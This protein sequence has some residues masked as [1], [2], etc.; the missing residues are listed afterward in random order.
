MGCCSSLN[1]WRK[2]IKNRLE[3]DVL[4]SVVIDKHLQIFLNC[5]GRQFMGMDGVYLAIM[6]FGHV[7]LDEG[8]SEEEVKKISSMMI[9]Y[10]KGNRSSQMNGFFGE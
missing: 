1:S 3:P 4:P 8:V 7:L 6:Q 9:H 5:L 2:E 10:V